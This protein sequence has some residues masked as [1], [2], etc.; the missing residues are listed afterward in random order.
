M[1]H[2]CHVLENLICILF[3]LSCW[4]LKLDP[5]PKQIEKQEF[6]FECVQMF[7]FQAIKDIFC[8]VKE[9]N[10]CQDVE[11]LKACEGLF[12]LLFHWLCWFVV[13]ELT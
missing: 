1:S 10:S 8:C 5:G 2:F 11:V 3:F 12:L 13:A 7:V 9:T 6:Q 4:D